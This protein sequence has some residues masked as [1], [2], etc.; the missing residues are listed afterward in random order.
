MTRERDKALEELASAELRYDSGKHTGV[1][2]RQAVGSEDEDG[3]ED[4]QQQVEML[5][6]VRV[7]SLG[8]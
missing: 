6:Q 1:G 3:D 2:K 8:H 7:Q 5:E 4:L